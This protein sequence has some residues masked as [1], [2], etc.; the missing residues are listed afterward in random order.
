MNRS[1]RVL[2]WLILL[3]GLTAVGCA[4][5][6]RPM[7]DASMPVT[8]ASHAV[9]AAFTRASAQPMFTHGYV[10]VSSRYIEPVDMAAFVV[11]G[12]DGLD[13]FDSRLDVEATADTVDVFL[14]DRRVARF[15]KP[16]EDR[17]SDWARL[18]IDAIQAARAVS[19][20]LAAA[21]AEAIYDALFDSALASLDPFSRYAGAAEA[22]L[23]RGSRNGF[24]GIGILFTI[25]ADGAVMVE[26]VVEGGPA[27]DA[28]LLAGD[29]I[30]AVDDVAFTR[31]DTD[32]VRERL[33]GPVGSVVHLSVVRGNGV[34]EVDL[35]R[36]LIV[37]PTVKL[38]V[39]DGIATLRL[40]SFN[41]ATTEG[42]AKAVQVA[43]AR[44]QAG[45]AVRGLIL[46]MRG[47][48]GG[49]LDQ[50]V[51]V[52]DLF[53]DHGTIVSTR[54][55]H[56]EARQFYS[57]SAGDVSGGLPIVVLMDGDSASAAEIVA[58]ALQDGGRAVVIGTTSYG[59]GTVQ[60]VVQLPNGGEITLTWSRFHSPS[61]YVLHGLGVPPV[62]CTS[63]RANQT[64][65]GVVE[66]VLYDLRTHADPIARRLSSW[67][68]TAFEDI[69][70]RRMLRNLCPAEHHEPNG[71]DE[72]VARRLLQDPSLYARAIGLV[73]AN[74]APR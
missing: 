74:A 6:R 67:Q 4:P 43:R 66:G 51:S 57:A 33:R 53:L 25:R 41:Q 19:P 59:K 39:E 34:L 21:D 18:S 14:G 22:R 5:T 17:G 35:E 47:N 8:D 12:L 48:P 56:P 31:P 44:A 62:A 70:R 50:S 61:G 37:M 2:S 45:E 28:G 55:R 20:P 64:A 38:S 63:G 60:T 11:A 13:R 23:N 24:G 54:G 65:P 16:E 10:A 42:V 49:L 29:Q 52:A 30:L 26:E 73:G 9:S 3:V 40:S 72:A 1:V 69:E 46:D 58:A 7:P 27:A 32:R 68:H 36:G 71:L 15:A